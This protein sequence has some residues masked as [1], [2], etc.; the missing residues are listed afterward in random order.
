MS[1]HI[2]E[3]Q[4]H[5]FYLY[6]EAYTAGTR[7]GGV[8]EGTGVGGEGWGWGLMYSYIIDKE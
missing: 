8:P 7:S 4:Y 5:E 2:I 1:L 3:S 6:S